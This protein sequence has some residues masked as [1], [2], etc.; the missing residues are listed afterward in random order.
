MR[1]SLTVLYL[2]VIAPT[3][4]FSQEQIEPL[5]TE[6]SPQELP[7]VRVEAPRSAT[8]AMTDS[9]A[10]SDTFMFDPT[11]M[12]GATRPGETIFGVTI[13]GSIPWSSNAIRRDSDRVGPYGSPVWT[14]QRPF[15]ASR[16]YVLPPG[17]AQV[18]QWVRPTWEH[19]GKPDF[20]MLEEY[21]MGL[22]GRFQLDLYERWNIQPGPNGLQK[23]DQEAVQVELRWALADWGKIILNPTLYGEWV[24]KSNGDPNVYEAKLLLSDEITPK[25]FYASNFIL[26]Q[27]TGGSYETELGWSNA[28]AVPVIE[29]KLLLGMECLLQ[30]NT[31]QGERGD[32]VDTFRIGPSMQIR[33][34]NRTFVTVT[35]LFG[36]TNVS[37]L[38]QAF[39]IAG[40]QFGFRAGPTSSYFAPSSTIGN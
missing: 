35:S 25:L 21:A 11:T 16:T 13:P 20:R 32:P 7:E 3:I 17:Q 30:R 18:E 12:Q 26:E 1:R 29:R 24:Q 31:V 14:T 2:L 10:G 34:T 22:P 33:P 15:A 5:P 23:A 9:G 38:C 4:I 27:E 37:P 39:F 19:Q 6:M 8:E 40:Y 36:T 28:L